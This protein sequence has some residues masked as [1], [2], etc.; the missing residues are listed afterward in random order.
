VKQAKFVYGEILKPVMEEGLARLSTPG[1]GAKGN[2][3]DQGS[4]V[5]WLLKYTPTADRANYSVLSQNQLSVSFAA[6]HTTAMATTHAV[7]DLIANPEFI[8]ELREEIEHVI[9]CD[10]YESRNDGT[11]R[12]KKSSFP[13]LQKLDSFMKESQRFSP[14]SLVS[15]V[16][17]TTS[18]LSLSTG[19]TI[20]KGTR[21]AFPAYGVN[22][23]EKTHS[24]SPPY[25]P[26]DMK[27]PTEFDGL[28]FYRLRAME[29]KEN[30]HQF[31]TT[32][33]DSLNFGHG[34]HACPGRFFASNEIKVIL[35]ELLMFYDF[36]MA[37][38]ELG[39]AYKRPPNIESK[40]SLL[41]DMK[42]V[43]EFRKRVL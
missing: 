38:G 16:R 9:A 11:K 42:A 15:N 41:P 18:K 39:I 32:A 34:N 22:M 4:F 14:P 43:L 1:L 24:F 2:H 31:V 26:P 5:S 30:R 13:K 8:P 6:I 20:P 25:N 36:R 29:G 7:Y 19:H 17:L 27:P 28:R 3:Q 21:V 12:L 10:G 23:S 37:G 33:S 40:L 35:I